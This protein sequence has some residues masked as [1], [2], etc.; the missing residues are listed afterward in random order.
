MA[1]VP[2]AKEPLQVAVGC[3][4]HLRGAER[5]VFAIASGVGP[6]ALGAVVAIEEGAC[7]RS[8]GLPVKR[9]LAKVVTR[10]RAGKVGRG[11]SQPGAEREHNH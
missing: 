11:G 1:K 2:L 7:G 3:G 6:V 8:A 5:G 10:G 9:V 4:T